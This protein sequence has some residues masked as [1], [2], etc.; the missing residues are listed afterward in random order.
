ML[1]PSVNLILLF[2]FAYIAGSINFAILLFKF[3]GKEDPRN[4]FSGNPGT[5]NVYRQAGIPWAAMVLIL[6]MGRAVF[7][8]LVALNLLKTNS[9]PWIGFALIL[10]NRFPCFHQFKGGKGVANFLGFAAVINPYTASAGMLVWVATFWIIRI[11]FISSF[12]MVLILSAGMIM[13]IGF[14]PVATSGTLAT[15]VFIF[16]SH[17]KN[18]AEFLKN[19]K[20]GKSP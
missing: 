2:I 16:Y 15:A 3:L 9:V 17:K 20:Q 19:R 12:I 10:G 4:K 1:L 8:A 18:L 7:I 5:S 13:S 6:D 11:P 14:I